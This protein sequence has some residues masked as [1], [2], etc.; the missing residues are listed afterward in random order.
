[1]DK[2]KY[3]FIIEYN[4]DVKRLVRDTALNSIC[5]GEYIGDFKVLKQ[6]ISDK[7]THLK[8]EM[9]LCHL[10]YPMVLKQDKRKMT[11]M[12]KRLSTQYF[13]SKTHRLNT[14]CEYIMIFDQDIFPAKQKE[15]ELQ[16]KVSKTLALY[17]QQNVIR[18]EKGKSSIRLSD[19]DINDYQMP[20]WSKI[21]SH[22]RQT[23]IGIYDA[24]SHIATALMAS[25]T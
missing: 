7:V 14:F 19:I 21:N 15:L 12:F 10:Y 24:V 23:Y 18:E 25:W 8:I 20:E 22:F 13:P 16:L 9:K 6:V 4:F 2:M 17:I 11:V 5:I 1:M 3:G